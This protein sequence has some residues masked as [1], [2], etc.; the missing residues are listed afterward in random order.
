MLCLCGVGK[1]IIVWVLCH[2]N[3]YELFQF[4]TLFFL[5]CF[6]ETKA[7]LE[8]HTLCPY[9]QENAE[10]LWQIADKG[11]L[12]RGRSLSKW[13][14]STY[15]TSWLSFL[16]A[17]CSAEKFNPPESGMESLRP[18][19]QFLF[20]LAALSYVQWPCLF[21][22][23]FFWWKAFFLDDSTSR[24]A[25]QR[26][27]FIVTWHIKIERSKTGEFF[28][29]PV[30]PSLVGSVVAQC[31]LWCTNKEMSFLSAKCFHL[32]CCP[33]NPFQ[34]WLIWNSALYFLRMLS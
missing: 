18:S 4:C 13:Y 17:G 24:K 11:K 31:S 8:R 19:L 12:W 20:F 22:P 34:K 5:C 27:K 30:S 15:V 32:A 2:Y 6:W 33:K 26:S 14:I 29:K 3:L 16:I 28:D 21:T 7:F 9:I 23:L 10:K 1:L 25:M